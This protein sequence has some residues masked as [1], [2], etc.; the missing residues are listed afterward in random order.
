VKQFSTNLE[1]RL[2]KQNFQIDTG[3]LDLPRSEIFHSAR[4]SISLFFQISIQRIPGNGKTIPMWHHD[5]RLGILKYRLQCLLCI[6][7]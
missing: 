2:W 7:S 3:H 1:N 4:N 5:W 6:E